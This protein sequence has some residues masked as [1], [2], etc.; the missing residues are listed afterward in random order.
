MINQF[1]YEAT[2]QA[3]GFNGYTRHLKE[4]E[5]LADAIKEAQEHGSIVAKKGEVFCITPTLID[6]WTKI[7]AGWKSK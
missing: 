1:G 3:S 2:D 7:N 6:G 5:L 4:S